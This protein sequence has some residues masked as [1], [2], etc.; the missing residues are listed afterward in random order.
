MTSNNLEQMEALP[1]EQLGFDQPNQYETESATPLDQ[2]YD[3]MSQYS[4]FNNNTPSFSSPE[5]STTGGFNEQS[6][7]V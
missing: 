2:T 7:T 3:N 4:N 1:A 6:D 5:T